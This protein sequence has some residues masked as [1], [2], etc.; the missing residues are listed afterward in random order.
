MSGI[1][2]IKK[3]KVTITRPFSN[4]NLDISHECV[5]HNLTVS[6]KSQPHPYD[7]KLFI[8]V[9]DPFYFTNAKNGDNYNWAED[10]A[11]LD[12]SV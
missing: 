7:L 5:Y 6:K 1:L 9:H 12:T 11:Q 8:I 10:S 3:Y 4:F 2:K